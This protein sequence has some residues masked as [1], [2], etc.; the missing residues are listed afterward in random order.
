MNESKQKILQWIDL[1]K[2]KVIQFLQEL[3]TIPSD[4]PPGDCS[5]I[6][7]HIYKRLGHFD[8][9]QTDL[10][11]I[12]PEEVRSN[13]MIR[14]ANIVSRTIFGNG[15]GPEIALN[16]H[17]DV[18]AP[19][20][21][22]TQ[23]PYGGKIVDGKL[24]GRGAAVSKSDIAAYT[25]AVM[26]LRQVAAELSGK[27]VLAFNFDEETG[28]NIGV[29]RMI[30]K[31]HIRPDMAISAGFSYSIVNSHNG[32]LHLE[33]QLK[34]KS[35]HAAA[36]YTGH[37]ALE[38]MTGVLQSIYT[39]RRSL[40][41][42]HSNVPGIDSPT[43]VVGLVSGGINTNVVPDQCTIRIDRRLIPEEDGEKVERELRQLVEQTVRDYEG[44]QVEIRRILLA[45]SFK[46]TPEN[47]PLIQT[48]ASNWKKV[49]GGDPE[50]HGIPLYT[51]ARHF[52]EAGIPVILFG[53]GPRTLLEANG[54]RADEH[55]RIGDLIQATKILALTLYDLL[56]EGK[57]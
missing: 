57:D 9:S 20:L 5:A 52:A 42:I 24:Y 17:G 25:F 49:M 37:D 40:D 2:E 31:G 50:I 56:R 26:A 43:L 11:E 47:S 48:L 12:E 28:G 54:H 51:D 4:N 29:K 46:P 27:A 6:A 21:G 7:E 15:E 8:F 53:A 14:V 45:K 18:V 22:W 19:G 3:V 13:G 10:L 35:A 1:E 38:A 44:I 55:V 32:C 33:V 16:A 36:P 30:E 34:G 23:D 39:Y 41:N